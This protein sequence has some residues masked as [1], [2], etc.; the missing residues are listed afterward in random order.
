VKLMSLYKKKN[1]SSIFFAFFLTFLSLFFSVS[2]STID[3]SI[4][5]VLDGKINGISFNRTSETGI[6]MIKLKLDNIGS[7]PFKSRA[8]MEILDHQKPVYNLW[9]NEVE[10]NPSDENFFEFFFLI[11]KTGIFKSNI[12]VYYGG[13]FINHEGIPFEIENITTKE[14]IF[15]VSRIRADGNFIKF[16]LKGKKD[17]KNT[18]IFFSNYPKSWIIEENKID[19]LEKGNKIPVKIKYIP[20]SSQ[21]NND[22]KIHVFSE[23]GNFYTIENV[24]LKEETGIKKLVNSFLDFLVKNTVF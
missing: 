6:V 9:S 17:A 5:E 1:F 24:A 21:V 18:L 2:C 11:N 15:E 4:P 14:S 20:V 8:R 13:E 7:I 3:V 19:S 22:I 12:R 23:D 10:L 16:D